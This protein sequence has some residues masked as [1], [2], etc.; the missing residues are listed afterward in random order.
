MYITS[1]CSSKK[2]QTRKKT[3]LCTKFFQKIKK[4]CK[5]SISDF[6]LGRCCCPRQ[7]RKRCPRSRRRRAPRR[8]RGAR[9]D[10]RPRFLC[11]HGPNQRNQKSAK[12]HRP[13]GWLG[14]FGSMHVLRHF[15][16][17]QAIQAE[18]LRIYSKYLIG[19]LLSAY[20]GS[21]FAILHC[22]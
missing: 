22:F 15:V 13:M 4:S 2:N 8:R 3:F 16:R 10:P 12:T 11:K 6:I 20:F 9:K 5:T 19:V 1:Q 17:T 21:Q 7:R 14:R 18:K